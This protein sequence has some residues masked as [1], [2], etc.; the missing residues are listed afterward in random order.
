MPL[1]T[2]TALLLA[3]RIRVLVGPEASPLGGTHPARD[4][5]D[6]EE[7][8]TFM[9]LR[10]L[11]LSA[12]FA[13]SLRDNTSAYGY[14]V[15]ITGSYAILNCLDKG[16]STPREIFAAA[17]GA[18]VAFTLIQGLG[19]RFSKSLDEVASNRTRIIARM[20]DLA[21]VGAAMGA[22]LACGDYLSGS[23]AWFA[24]TFFSSCIFVFIDA[25]ELDWVQRKAE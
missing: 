21:S 6:V 22:A 19:L 3:P 8:P 4:A 15:T 11:P 25:L 14:S 5:A 13:I 17:L 10:S 7:L 20:M 2:T 1:L 24:A 23:A 16:S 18:V 12:G 9:N